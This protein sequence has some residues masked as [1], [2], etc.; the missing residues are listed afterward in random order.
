[1]P[2]SGY[3]KTL[4]AENGDVATV[5][6]GVQSDGTVS[7]AQGFGPYYQLP[8]TDPNYLPVPRD[9]YN[10]ILRD[11]TA[12]IQ[13]YQQFGYPAFITSVMNGGS[14]YAYKKFAT[15]YLNGA[16]YQSLV[17]N[18]TDT[19]PSANWAAVP[20]GGTTFTTGD[21]KFTL[22]SVADTGWIMANDGT[23]GSA[24]SGATTLADASA[25]ALYTL[26]WNNVSDTYAPVTGGRGASAAA[27]W[28]ANKK[29]AL[30]KMLGRALAVAGG[31]SGLTPYN[32]GQT[33][34][35]NAHA[36]TANEN[37]QHTHTIN[38][39][40]HNHAYPQ[41]NA[42]GNSNICGNSYAATGYTNSNVTGITIN[43]SGAGAAHNN[44]QPTSFL[45][46]MIKL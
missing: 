36:L 21:V 30:T 2:N 9:K 14:A 6:D 46:V 27:D 19:P 17:D 37:G 42:G 41:Y 13:Q 26:I 40:G 8:P 10:Q 23:I 12:A 38:D 44:M 11:L 32:I 28:A 15:V 43:S 1:M 16:V 35:E 7:Y 22:K 29:I 34:G 45:N 5:P 4:F 39:P 25:Q 31:G 24:S 3:F 18:N 20:L 33:T